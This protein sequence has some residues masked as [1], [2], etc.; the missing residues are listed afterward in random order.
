MSN[1]S[2]LNGI[3][4]PWTDETKALVLEETQ[5]DRIEKKLDAVLLF[6]S[7]MNKM[8]EG[9]MPVIADIENKGIGAIFGMFMGGKK[10]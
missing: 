3:G 1:E 4:V 5:M 6:A 2:Q 7:E 9:L 8:V 10:K